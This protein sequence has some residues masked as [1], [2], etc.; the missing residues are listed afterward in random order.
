L[1]AH[2]HHHPLSHIYKQVNSPDAKRE[3]WLLCGVNGKRRQRARALS[4]DLSLSL[5]ADVC[6]DV[7]GFDT[8]ARE[9]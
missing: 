3:V 5:L 8:H 9:D 7:M 4:I 2:T 1:N 6:M